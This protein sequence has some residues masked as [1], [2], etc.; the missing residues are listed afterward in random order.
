MAVLFVNVVITSSPFSLVSC[1]L[2]G[3]HTEKIVEE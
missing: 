3:L 1:S 2:F